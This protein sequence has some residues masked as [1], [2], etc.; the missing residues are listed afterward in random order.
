[1]SKIL[2]T[3]ATGH[4]GSTVINTLSAHLPADQIS[5]ITRKEDQRQS[6][7][8]KGYTAHLADYDDSNSLQQAMTGI[9]TV[10]LVSAGDQGNRI[11]Q[12]KNVIDAARQAGVRSVAYTSRSLKDRYTLA[13]PLMKDHFETEDYL[14]ASGLT[15]TLFRNALYLDVLPLFLGQDAL[16]TGIFLPAGDGQVAYALREEMAEGIANVLLAQHAENKTYTFTGNQAYSFYD[17]AA[18]L[19]TLT[20]KR[21]AYTPLTTSEFTERLQQRNMPPPV[22]KKIVDFNT[23]IEQNQESQVTDHLEK[24]LGRK[25]ATLENGLKK[26]F[27]L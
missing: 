23:D 18:A 24:I 13:N 15:Y 27:A 8:S 14:Q 3:G 20:G 21:L 5:V 4:L 25:P 19:S 11:Q 16:T 6:L 1:M 17:V 9:D 26:L 12:H 2:V 10:L 7:Q 22:I